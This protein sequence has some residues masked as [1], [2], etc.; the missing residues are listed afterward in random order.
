M[1]SV[2][3]HQLWAL[4]NPFRGIEGNQSK[5]LCFGRFSEPSGPPRGPKRGP[6]HKKRWAHQSTIITKTITI[7]CKVWLMTKKNLP[8]VY[9]ITAPQ[10]IVQTRTDQRRLQSRGPNSITC[11][12]VWTLAILRVLVP[13]RRDTH[14]ETCTISLNNWVPCPRLGWVDNLHANSVSHRIFEMSFIRTLDLVYE[15]R[16]C[17]FWMKTVTHACWETCTWVEG[18]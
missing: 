3:F 11:V 1:C 7:I 5:M 9:Y 14:T 6:R 17:N 10:H 8:N 15:G 2:M 12:L 18:E 16:R 13:H 4:S